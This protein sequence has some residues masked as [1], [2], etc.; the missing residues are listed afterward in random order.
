M[1]AIVTMGTRVMNAEEIVSSFSN[2]SPDKYYLF[3]GKPTQW[4]DEQLPDTPIDTL[5]EEVKV[6]RDIMALD[7]IVESDVCLGILRRDWTT[8]RYYD[9]YRHD[10]GL[11]GVAGVNLVDGSPTQPES[12]TDANFYVVTDDFNVYMCMWNNNG[13]I[14][15][16]KPTGKSTSIITTADGYQWKYLMSISSADTLKFSSTNF[17]PVRRITTA[18]SIADPYYS[19]WEVR[20]AAVPGTI[21]RILVSAS[22]SGYPVSTSFAVTVIGDGTGCTA[23]ANTNSSGNITS[24]TVTNIGL[25][26]S[27]AEVQIT[28]GSNAVANPIIAPRGGYGYDPV[29]MLGA[30]YSLIGVQLPYDADDFPSVNEYRRIGVLRSPYNYGSTTVATAATLNATR[31]LNCTLGTIGTFA[32]DE[33]IV[34]STSGARATVVSAASNKLSTIQIGTQRGAFTVNETITGV[35]SGATCILSSITQPEVDTRSGDIVYLEHR[36]PI[37]RQP[38]QV[39]SIKII[40]ES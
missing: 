34:G 29:T 20:A 30:H 3:I 9:I 38:D 17:I 32:Q 15:T 19:Q 12:L 13:G 8:N 39:E 6:R 23:V 5:K 10:Y 22:G 7:R 28:G 26:Y 4:A 21:N 40:I 35:T 36:R 25:G 14:S 11:A 18:P 16:V 2:T 24:V 27:W 33:E 37:S 31:I 1:T